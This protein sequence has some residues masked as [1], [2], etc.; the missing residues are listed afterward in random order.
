MQL[1][2]LKGLLNSG[3]PHLSLIKAVRQLGG[4]DQ[5]THDVINLP[6]TRKRAMDITRT[7]S[8]SE[9]QMKRDNND[10]QNNYMASQN[11]SIPIENSE[12]STMQRIS[13]NDEI[14][15]NFNND[16]QLESTTY[17]SSPVPTESKTITERLLR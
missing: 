6:A 8:E 9:P 5:I 2:L 4:L 7:D 1:Q 14:Q 17:R 12:L 11:T 10:S 3:V 13:Q 16:E 15:P